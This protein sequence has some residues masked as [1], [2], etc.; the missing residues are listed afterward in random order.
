M[1]EGAGF[2]GLGRDVEGEEGGELG[3][4]VADEGLGAAGAEGR[5][6]GGEGEVGDGD[7][8]RVVRVVP[9][10]S[11]LRDRRAG[12]EGI[13]GGRGGASVGDPVE[14]VFGGGAEGDDCGV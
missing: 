5:C 14:G 9:V 2:R 12:G 13:V 1:G 3:L 6:G 7:R 11:D 10:E 4:D 8:V